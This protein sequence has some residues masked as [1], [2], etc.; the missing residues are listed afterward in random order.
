MKTQEQI[1]NDIAPEWHEYKK[2]ASELSIDFLNKQ[3]GKILDLGS[4]SGRHLMKIKNGKMYLVDFSKEMIELAEKK[5]KEQNIDADFV[6]AGMTKLPFEDEFF[7]SGISISAIHCTPKKDHKKI[8]KE[9]YRVLKPKAKFLVG[10]WNKESK[11]FKKYKEN[12]RYIGW[13]D[14]GKRYYYLFTENEIHDLFTRVGFKIIQEQN[15][16]LMIRFVVEK[17]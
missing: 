16:E 13:Q 8:V 3:Q 9:L 7:D 11:R 5:A 4:G 17:V 10:V 14:K 2:R 1:W 15:S 6:V 12:E